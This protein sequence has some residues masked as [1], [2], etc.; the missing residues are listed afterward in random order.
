MRRATL[1][2]AS[3]H[4]VAEYPRESC[5]L[6]VGVSGRER[7]VPCRNVAGTPSEHF[8]LHPEDYGRAEDM[9][10][11]L[12]VVHSHPGHPALPSP[13]DL[14]GCEATGLPW[15]IL[16][17]DRDEADGSVS[18]TEVH[19]WAPSGWMAELVGRPFSYGTLDCW[20]LVRD[21]YRVERGVELPSIV[22]GPDGWWDVDDAWSPYEDEENWR[23]AGFSRANDGR[24]LIGDLVVM[25]VRSR[26]GKPNHVGV[27]IDDQ[28][29]I[30][31]HHLYDGLSERTVYGGYWRETTR[32]VLRRNAQ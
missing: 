18:V 2:R 20:G 32:L 13:G 14:A 7:Y 30:M 8:V 19:S 1:K 25:Q 12:G 9:G 23:R 29:C 17:V 4:A 21:W 16:R 3:E 28:R 15:T 10:E 6:V 24:L 31:L 5:G 26:A 27:I 22:R 11:V